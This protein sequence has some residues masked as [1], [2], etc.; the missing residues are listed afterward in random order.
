MELS[1]IQGTMG[2]QMDPRMM[3]NSKRK[4][5]FQ[6]EPCDWNSKA[7]RRFWKSAV[8]AKIT[9]LLL[10]LLALPGKPSLEGNKQLSLHRISRSGAAE[11]NT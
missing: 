5:S 8:V 1:E 10:L 2:K 11:I 4:Q 6:N 9:M 3:G 7:R